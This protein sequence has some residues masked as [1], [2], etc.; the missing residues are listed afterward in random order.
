MPLLLSAVAF[1]IQKKTL[2]HGKVIAFYG[3][4]KENRTP[5]FSL[6]S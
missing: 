2:P 4:G 3:A 6:G 5:I 1:V